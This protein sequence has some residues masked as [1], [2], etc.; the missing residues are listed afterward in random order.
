MIG[1][2]ALVVIDT[3]SL[4]QC[5]SRRSRYHKIW[6]SVLEGHHVMCVSNEML[7]EYE[8]VLEREASHEFARLA[9]GVILNNPN[10]KFIVP[11]YHFNLIEKDPD[12]NKFVDCAIS[13]NAKYII[14]EDKHYEVLK[15]IDFPHVEVIGLDEFISLLL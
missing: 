8:E 9:L 12:D 10:I 7:E 5:I 3:N 4:I 13:A 2:M 1:G 15:Q 6:Q 14:T 11:Y